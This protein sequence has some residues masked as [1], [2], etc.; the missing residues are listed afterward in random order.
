MTNIVSN[1]KGI[2]SIVNK[3]IPN[4]KIILKLGNA[5][6]LHELR[7]SNT[8]THFIG[9]SVMDGN[10]TYIC[11]LIISTIVH[12]EFFYNNDGDGEVIIYNE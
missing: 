12:D 2:I 3:F 4:S 9:E 5:H 11:I 1:A 10:T 7:D 6:F 8:C